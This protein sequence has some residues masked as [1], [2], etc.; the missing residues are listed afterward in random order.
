MTVLYRFNTVIVGIV[1]NSKTFLYFLFVRSAADYRLHLWRDDKSGAVSG[2]DECHA[3]A[4][5]HFAID[6]AK[7]GIECRLLK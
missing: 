4:D 7:C 3:G 5:D 6:K 2:H 1:I